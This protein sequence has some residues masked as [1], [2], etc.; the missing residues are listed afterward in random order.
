MKRSAASPWRG[1][2]A[3]EKAAT[4]AHEATAAP[5][6][7]NAHGR[8][9]K[10]SGR[11]LGCESQAKEG[12]ACDEE[13]TGTPM[14]CLLVHTQLALDHMYCTRFSGPALFLCGGDQTPQPN[15]EPRGRPHAHGTQLVAH[16]CVLASPM[17]A[18]P[19]PP[20]RTHHTLARPHP[21]LQGAKRSPSRSKPARYGQL[22]EPPL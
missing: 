14:G 20:P 6:S 21:R 5:V 22:R 19:L 2:S 8:K 16:T 15:N 4:E 9:G 18:T 13:A 11:G 12:R 10:G 17:T 3:A 1:R 7:A